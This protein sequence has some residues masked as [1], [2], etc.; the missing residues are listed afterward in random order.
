[1]PP[2]ATRRHGGRRWKRS[3][4]WRGWMTSPPAR[5]HCPR[6]LVGEGDKG[7]RSRS[8]PAPAGQVVSDGGRALDL[9]RR[10]V[11]RRSER[12]YVR[13]ER[14]PRLAAREGEGARGEHIGTSRR[15]SS[16]TVGAPRSGRQTDPLGALGPG[17]PAA[18]YGFEARAQRDGA[19]TY[20]HTAFALTGDPKFQPASNNSSSGAIT[21]TPC[22]RS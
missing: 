10:H 4:P 8:A 9:E 5:L 13:R 14:V 21:R 12:S 6:H 11:E 3:K 18:A 2:P 17:V 16:T 7:D 20:V 1:M 19:Q 15:T 22:A